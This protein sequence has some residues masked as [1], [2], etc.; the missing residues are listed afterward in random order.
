MRMAKA[1]PPYNDP[2]E[3]IERSLREL[4]HDVL[5]SKYGPQWH[6]NDKAGLGHDWLITL[7]EALRS[8]EGVLKPEVSYDLP[9]AYAEFSDLNKLL[10]KN[11]DLFLPI[12][13]EWE[14]FQVFLH[15]AEKLR[16][17]VKHHRD[18]NPSQYMLLE[19]IAGEIEAA[20]N[21][22]RIGTKLDVRKTTFQYKDKLPTDGRL[23]DEILDDAS[24]VIKDWS[25]KI[26]NAIL[27]AGL[28]L[29]K[30]SITKSEYE[31]DFQGQHIHMRFYTGSDP[32]PI[33]NIDGQNFKGIYG[34]LVTGAGCRTSIDFLLSAIGEPYFHLAYE[35]TGNI[36]VERLR[37]WSRDRAGLNP[38]SSGKRGA[39]L[40]DIEYS[41]LG[42]RVRVG[43]TRFGR[44]SITT[45]PS[46][47]FWRAHAELDARKLIGFMV[48]SISP[49]S[50]MHLVRMSQIPPI[51]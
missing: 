49:K 33:M 17:I 18:L 31:C 21:F 32:R 37:C 16:N 4:I 24:R 25:K 15:T 23:D 39:E 14:D 30:F 41:L 5:S 38:S 2:I 7:E 22:W 9:L 10:E 35:V 51:N 13:T 43:A 26:E 40:T 44:L 12:F 47:G 36:D 42:G 28:D 3:L 48:G 8:D 11:K 46:E 29:A 19:G 50:M 45:D 20:I 6:K 27:R 1:C 34:E